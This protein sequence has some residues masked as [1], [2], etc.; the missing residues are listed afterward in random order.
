MTTHLPSEDSHHSLHPSPPSQTNLLDPSSDL[1]QSCSFSGWLSLLETLAMGQ[2]CRRMRR[3]QR[4]AQPEFLPQVTSFWPGTPGDLG[5]SYVFLRSE[6]S[7][8]LV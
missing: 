6:S 5:V 3:L 2:L 4:R 8:A 7:A 1:A